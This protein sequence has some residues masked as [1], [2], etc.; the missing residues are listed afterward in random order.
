MNVRRKPSLGNYAMSCDYILYFVFM[1]I[2]VY[3][4]RQKWLTRHNG[5]HFANGTWKCIF[6]SE[7]V[8]NL[9]QI[10]LTFGSKGPFGNMAALVHVM[11][12]HRTEQATSHWLKQRWPSSLTHICDTRGWWGKTF[13]RDS[14][15]VIEIWAW[16]SNNIP[17][18][19]VDLIIILA[20]TV[21]LILLI[22]AFVPRINHIHA[23]LMILMIMK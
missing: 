17:Q 18:Y 11:A 16:L 3:V 1:Y 20:L 21:M 5:R 22:A 12:W 15:T 19:C 10:P 13:H 23:I 2:S 7:N 8:S 14:S 9:I 6:I 4:H